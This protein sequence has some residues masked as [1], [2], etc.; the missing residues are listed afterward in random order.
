M[1][2]SQVD[3][4][5]KELILNVLSTS[6]AGGALGLLY[7]LGFEFSAYLGI[8]IGAAFGAAVGFRLTRKPLR[9]RY[10]LFMLRRILLA[11]TFMLLASSI[12]S[13]LLDQD[14]SQA[15]RYWIT[16]LPL[17]GWTAVVV[18]IGMLIASLD[19]LQRRIQTEAIA[20]GFAITAVFVGGYALFQFAGLP[21]INLGLAL[22]AMSAAWLIGKLWTLWRYR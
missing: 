12:Y 13:Y 10:P 15:Q 14:I 20:I 1:N 16:I 6:L 8:L 3:K 17:L 4:N 7:A 9:M 11:A 18:T 5:N 22:M 19:E 21:E 2:A